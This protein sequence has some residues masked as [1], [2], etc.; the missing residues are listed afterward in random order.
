MLS[1]FRADAFAYCIWTVCLIDMYHRC[2][3][4]RISVGREN[5]RTAWCVRVQLVLEP[6][7]FMNIRTSITPMPRTLL[8]FLIASILT[9]LL[10]SIIACSVRGIDLVDGSI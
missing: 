1:G 10:W 6:G 7:D 4:C 5:R 9:E 8:R 3:L 2:I